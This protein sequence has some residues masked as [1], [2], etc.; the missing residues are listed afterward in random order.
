M[1]YKI[2]FVDDEQGIL[3]SLKRQLRNRFAVETALG[4]KKGLA[5]IAQNGPYAVI[6]SDL[7][8]PEMDGIQFLA[9]ASTEAP[10]SVRIM[11][12]GNADLN[13]AIQAVN[14]GNIFR[15]L[16]KPCEMDTLVHLLDKGIEQYRLVTAEKE[17]LEKTLK[18]SINMLTDLLSMLNPEAF[19]R[20]ARIREYALEVAQHL[21]V[22]ELWKIETAA[23]LS[24]IGCVALPESL[25]RKRH[26]GA[27]LT[28][29]ELRVYETHPKI[30][31]D[32]LSNIPRIEDVAEV[33]LYQAKQYD[34][35]GFPPDAKKKEDLPVG[36]RILKAVLDFDLF[37]SK[38]SP[39]P[40]VL[41]DLRMRAGHYDPDILSA[42][43]RIMGVRAEAL[44][45][46]VLIRELEEG[47]VFA[48]DVMAS[49]NR[50]LVSRGQ[51][52]SQMMIRRLKNF[53]RNMTI[54]EPLKVIIPR[55]EI[56]PKSEIEHFKTTRGPER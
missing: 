43:E 54:K 25:V 44:L 12:T 34:G 19:G 1:P 37:E 15:F 26:E 32:L 33:I 10:D 13:N 20:S 36:A 8:M 11:L 39:K 42:L 24:Q 41:V 4:P 23:M 45:K 28:D 47:M 55:P 7:R 35:S 50:M 56:K 14:E 27:D 29:E 2:L 31:A 5:A 46:D 22:S 16:T 49:G 38:G 6:V 21:G 52:I 3:D 53:A 9:R 18:G 48:E 40:A 51:E 17:L 30:A